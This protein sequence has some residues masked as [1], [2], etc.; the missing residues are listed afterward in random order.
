VFLVFDKELDELWLDRIQHAQDGGGILDGRPILRVNKRLE[1]TAPAAS[2][3]AEI[4]TGIDA[5]LAAYGPSIRGLSA[6]D[7]NV[8]ATSNAAFTAAGADD[9]AVVRFDPAKDSLYTH[10]VGKGFSPEVSLVKPDGSPLFVNA[11]PGGKVP[12]L[13]P[14]AARATSGRAT[15]SRPRLQTPA[16][17]ARSRLRVPHRSMAP[18]PR[19]TAAVAVVL[20]MHAR[21]RCLGRSWVF[22]SLQREFDAYSQTTTRRSKSAGSAFRSSSRMTSGAT[23]I[24]K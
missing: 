4:D 19:A 13:D 17:V 1:P 21:D 23:R 5:L 11:P 3:F 14:S 10:L 8:P 12:G 9:L 22:S 18:R 24:E 16:T 7:E 6:W 2:I 20:L 15:E